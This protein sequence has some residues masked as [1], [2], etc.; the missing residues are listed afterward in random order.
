VTGANIARGDAAIAAVLLTILA[1]GCA[2]EQQA[3]STGGGAGA[4]GAG[5]LRTANTACL[6]ARAAAAQSAARPAPSAARP[7]SSPQARR[8]RSHARRSLPLATRTLA[9]LRKL[10]PSREERDALARLESEYQ[11]LFTLY[12]EAA[13]PGRRRTGGLVAAVGTAEENV[14]AQARAA[15]LPG[16]SP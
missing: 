14:R 13:A 4:R 8:V 9:V 1:L 2:D 3:A 5:F 10:R 11:R 15:R 12:A 7:P 16:C 6:Q